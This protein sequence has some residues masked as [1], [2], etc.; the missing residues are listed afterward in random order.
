MR[1]RRRRRAGGLR[2][3]RS[4]PW[5]AVGGLFVLLWLAISTSVYAPWWGVILHVLILVPL[6]GWV[7]SW[8]RTRPTAC[9]FVPLAGLPLLALVTAVGVGPGGWSA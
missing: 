6:V 5:I 7:A 9:T 1:R 4:G 2:L 3:E 8:A